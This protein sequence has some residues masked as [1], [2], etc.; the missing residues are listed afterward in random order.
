MRNL[1]TGAM[2]LIW[3]SK[4]N[5]EC[6]SK[7]SNSYKFRDKTGTWHYVGNSPEMLK[8]MLS[9]MGR[10]DVVA[11]LKGN[12]KDPIL[13]GVNGCN[14]EMTYEIKKWEDVEGMKKQKIW[15][16]VKCGNIVNGGIIGEPKFLNL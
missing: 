11:E 14:G 9:Q 12:E 8:D 10:P 1:T 15:T 3:M 6:I 4:D 13:C 7:E 16:C 2:A 5:K